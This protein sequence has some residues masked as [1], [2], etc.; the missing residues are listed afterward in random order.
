MEKNIVITSQIMYNMLFSYWML[1]QFHKKI[2]HEKTILI[3]IP[4]LYNSYLCFPISCNLKKKK[5]KY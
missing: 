2:W 3:Y 1:V 4:F 5:H